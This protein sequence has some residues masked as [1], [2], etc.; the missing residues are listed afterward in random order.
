[1]CHFQGAGSIEQAS[2]ASQ[3]VS[4]CWEVLNLLLSV[5]FSHFFKSI[6]LE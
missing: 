4:A 3:L 1:M 6:F 5:D 2:F